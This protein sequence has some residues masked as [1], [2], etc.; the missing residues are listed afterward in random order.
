MEEIAACSNIWL[1]VSE[2]GLP[3]AP[4]T[5]DGNRGVVRE[6]IRIF[7]VERCM[8]GSNWPVS[9]LRASFGVIVDGLAQIL[10][11]LPEDALDAFFYRNARH[12]Y[13]IAVPQD[14]PSNQE[15]R[16]GDSNGE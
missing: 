5:V 9:T 16:E 2:L 10:G 6:A 1:K 7:G 14:N 13:R 8:F 11:D 12:F 3:N 4:W 15:P